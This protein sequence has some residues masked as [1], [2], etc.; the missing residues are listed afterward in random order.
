MPI[1]EGFPL[2]KGYMSIP[3]S[4]RYIHE[5]LP[6]E[7]DATICE[8]LLAKVMLIPYGEL[9][10]KLA[11]TDTAAKSYTIKKT[12]SDEELKLTLRERLLPQTVLFGDVDAD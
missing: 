12:A 9:R 2:I 3:A 1:Y 11:S 6:A 4:S 8:E 10:Q 5:A 7:L